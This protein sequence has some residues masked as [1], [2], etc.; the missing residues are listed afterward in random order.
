MTAFLIGFAVV[1]GLC[2]LAPRIVADLFR[3]AIAPVEPRD[4]DDEEL[5]FWG[6]K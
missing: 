3:Q 2:I 4:M 6:M 1:A 5:W